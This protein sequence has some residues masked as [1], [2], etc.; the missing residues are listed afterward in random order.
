MPVR[1]VGK[2]AEFVADLPPGEYLIMFSLR[3]DDTAA[4]GEA[5]YDFEVVVEG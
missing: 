5:F 4:T 2:R 1:T 3:V